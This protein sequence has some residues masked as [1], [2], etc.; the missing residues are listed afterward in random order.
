M[1]SGN[2]LKQL[3][4]SYKRGDTKEF[5]VIA[6]EIIAEEEQRNHHVLARD[7]KKILENNNGKSVSSINKFD[8]EPLP[9]DSERGGT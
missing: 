6:Q 2:L 1:S 9:K 4:A 8:L 7:L 3:F 5:Y